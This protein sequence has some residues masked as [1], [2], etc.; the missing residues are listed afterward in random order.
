MLSDVQ[1]IVESVL[2]GLKSL[3]A[4]IKSKMFPLS[5]K[6]GHVS[7]QWMQGRRERGWAPGQLVDMGP[8]L[9]FDTKSAQLG[10]FR[11]YYVAAWRGQIK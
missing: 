3:S 7:L 4:L 8:L 1:W 9:N 10:E 2:T 5:M 11:E 6:S